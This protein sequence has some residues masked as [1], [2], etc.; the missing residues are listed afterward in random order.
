MAHKKDRYNN[1]L[2]ETHIQLVPL[3]WPVKGSDYG[4]RSILVVCT[5][6]SRKAYSLLPSLHEYLD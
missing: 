2:L 6:N 1:L 3:I 4:R 5:I